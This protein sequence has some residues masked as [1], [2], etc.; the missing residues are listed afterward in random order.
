MKEKP[1]N[2]PGFFIGPNGPIRKPLPAQK[3]FSA[4]QIL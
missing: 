1:G 4:D 2:P 3:R